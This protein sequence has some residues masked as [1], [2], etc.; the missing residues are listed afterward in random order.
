MAW[1]KI[2]CTCLSPSN[3]IWAATQV[4][5]VELGMCDNDGHILMNE[6]TLSIQ[7]LFTSECNRAYGRAII[8]TLHNIS[9][10]SWENFS[11]G[12]SLGHSC[13][14]CGCKGSVRCYCLHAFLWES[15]AKLIYCFDKY[16]AFM[17]MV[18]WVDSSLY[19]EIIENLIH[20]LFK[21]LLDKI[22]F[23]A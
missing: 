8:R 12:S 13:L 5:M 7:T 2:Q 9:K 15:C 14:Q 1:T 19:D 23:I 11:M 4:V 6:L 21:L 17:M 22:G 16:V 18:G 3:W 20:N 10:S